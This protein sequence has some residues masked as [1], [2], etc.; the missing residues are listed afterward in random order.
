MKKGSHLPKEGSCTA[1]FSDA[2]AENFN[3]AAIPAINAIIENKAMIKPLRYPLMIPV[4]RSIK[5]I[6]S[7][8]MP[9]LH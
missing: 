7:K 8:N 1:N 3:A 6:R 9:L 4:S 5:K 2:T